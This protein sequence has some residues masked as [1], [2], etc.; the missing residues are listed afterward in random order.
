MNPGTDPY[1]PPD[2][3]HAALLTIDVQNDFT[4]GGDARHAPGERAA[5]DFPWQRGQKLDRT[6]RFPYC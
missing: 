3:R 6:E 1:T 5:G 2:P 4:P